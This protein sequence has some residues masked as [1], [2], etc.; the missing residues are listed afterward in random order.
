MH[1]STCLNP[2]HI[3][4]MA[5]VCQFTL[6]CSHGPIFISFVSVTTFRVGLEALICSLLFSKCSAK[7]Y[8]LSL[9]L[10]GQYQH[11]SPGCQ[12]SSEI[13]HQIKLTQARLTVLIRR[14]CLR[15]LPLQRNF[16]W[17]LLESTRH[18]WLPKPRFGT[19][20]NNCWTMNGLR[21]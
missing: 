3:Q 11:L 16:Y 17:Q 14:T 7:N 9:I 21:K 2:T 18:G 15:P 13:P 4:R 10:P 5:A 8:R 19:P 20:S 12:P 6:T 1:S